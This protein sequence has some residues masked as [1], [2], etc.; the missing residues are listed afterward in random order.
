M[1][2]AGNITA[3]LSLNATPFNKGLDSSIS[4]VNRFVESVNK[5]SSTGAK[6]GITQLNEH[7]QNLKGTLKQVAEVNNSSLN[8]FSRLANAIN[9]M[10]NGLKI[11][12]SDA[13]NVE[14]A[15]N[16]MNSIFQSF[17]GA[18]N[19]VEVKVKGVS[20]SLSQLPAQESQAGAKQ[21]ELTTKINASKMS[22]VNLDST[23]RKSIND[24]TQYT[25]AT[26]RATAST[27]R[28]ATANRTATASSNQF[29]S[30]TNRLGRALS[31]LKM[32][33]TMVG[34]MLA[35]NFVHH[36]AQATN[37]TIQSKSEMEGYFK[38]LGY[39]Q[40]EIQKFNNVWIR[41]WQDSKE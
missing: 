24:I 20:S 15:V 27:Q 38:M 1:A 12:Q 32:M 34:S 6:D 35:Y 28:Q 9:K 33:G 10:A 14:Q 40:G 37:E 3:V 22:L 29:A 19:G 16:T 41:L 30:A 2:S 5:L 26:N 31:S 13:I 21:Q 11:L 25:S 39:G 7:L 8:T 4:A 17:Q 18:L 23:L 36:L